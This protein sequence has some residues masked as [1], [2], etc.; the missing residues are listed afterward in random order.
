MSTHTSTQTTLVYTERDGQTFCAR[1]TFLAGEQFRAKMSDVRK[2]QDGFEEVARAMKVA[3]CKAPEVAA[4]AVCPTPAPAVSKPQPGMPMFQLFPFAGLT[5]EEII[6][7]LI[8]HH[9]EENFEAWYVN[10][11]EST[12]TDAEWDD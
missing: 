11:T 5:N 3:V 2:R 6:R 10:E 1:P 9:M 8:K 12:T 4:P 7:G